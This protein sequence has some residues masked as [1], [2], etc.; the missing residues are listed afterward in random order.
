MRLNVLFRVPVVLGFILAGTILPAAAPPVLADEEIDCAA[1]HEPLTTG[2]S[3]HAAVQM[4]CTVCHSNVDASDV[5]HTFGGRNPKGLGSRL[6]DLCFNCHDRNNFMKKNVHPAII[7]GCNSCHNPHRSDV[8]RL[9]IEDIPGL[10]ITCHKER[11]VPG[12]DGSHQL[13]GNEACGSCHDP[14]SSNAPKLMLSERPEQPVATAAVGRS[15]TGTGKTE[16]RQ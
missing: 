11:F 15:A 1:C 9:L 13:A 7:L 2:T 10:C 8:A 3:V 14:H 16:E 5:P 12:K 4:G 6:R